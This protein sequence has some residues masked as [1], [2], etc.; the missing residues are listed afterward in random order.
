MKKIILNLLFKNPYASFAKKH[1]LYIYYNVVLSLFSLF[2]IPFAF[3]ILILKPNIPIDIVSLAIQI[4]FHLTL[5]ATY[6]VFC[7]FI[8]DH[9]L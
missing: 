4:I 6:L 8:S 2:L 7:V 1:S 5:H 3:G 9:F